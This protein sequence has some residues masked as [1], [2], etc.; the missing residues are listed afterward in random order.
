MDG[1]AA[2]FKPR[3]LEIITGAPQ[4][5]VPT[6]E[7]PK[8]FYLDRI[9]AISIFTHSCTT[10]SCDITP[11]QVTISEMP[12]SSAN[13]LYSSALLPFPALLTRGGI[14]GHSVRTLWVASNIISIPYTDLSPFTVQIQICFLFS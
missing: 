9:T 7:P 4:A 1:H 2:S 10:H 14:S 6:A 5:C 11:N 13:I 12:S 3:T 8:G